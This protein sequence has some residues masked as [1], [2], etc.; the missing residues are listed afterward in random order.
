[1]TELEGDTGI[2]FEYTHI[3]YQQV[4]GRINRMFGG[5]LHDATPLNWVTNYF[6]PDEGLDPLIA[7]KFNRFWARIFSR[8]SS[9]EKSMITRT[10]NALARASLKTVGALRDVPET[11]EVFFYRLGH[12]GLAFS[13]ACL[14]FKLQE[15]IS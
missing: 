1:M 5:E 11:Q 10:F 8:S 4:A 2:D 12:S 14:E 9:K 6:R 15:E 7:R 3:S 13:K